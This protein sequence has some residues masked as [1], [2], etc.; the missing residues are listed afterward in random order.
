MSLSAI[1]LAV[2]T[3]DIF[4]SFM[5]HVQREWII[6][7]EPIKKFPIEQPSQMMNKRVS[8][9]K[10]CTIRGMDQLLT[11]KP[12]PCPRI[13]SLNC[14]I[15]LS[16]FLFPFVLLVSF[17]CNWVFVSWED[18]YDKSSGPLLVEL[19][20]CQSIHCVCKEILSKWKLV[21][22]QPTQS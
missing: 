1:A 13:N 3:G 10:C 17:Y 7:S 6:E 8:S 12:D 18:S 15:T 5:F 19:I 14:L 21:S 22:I 11:L 16:G 9:S 4:W 20:L 2:V